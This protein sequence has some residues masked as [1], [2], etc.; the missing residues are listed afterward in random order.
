MM[1]YDKEFPGYGFARHKGYGTREHRE[2]IA[3]LGASP[4]HRRSF[5]VKPVLP[6]VV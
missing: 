1:Q 5:R 3:R 6:A 2:A 4:I